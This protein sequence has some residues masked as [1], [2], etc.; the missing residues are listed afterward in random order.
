MK[1][2]LLLTLLFNLVINASELTKLQKN[3]TLQQKKDETLIVSYKLQGK[4]Y[5]EVKHILE[6]YVKRQSRLN[7]I[8]GSNTFLL[9]TI[10]NNNF[11]SPE[12][13]WNAVFVEFLRRKG[14]KFDEAYVNGEYF[15]K[16]V[17]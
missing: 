16:K 15:L 11:T 9:T 6:A 12:E 7:L 17:N 10:E 3:L 13:L 2:F 4:S 5:A 14:M 1:K 8:G